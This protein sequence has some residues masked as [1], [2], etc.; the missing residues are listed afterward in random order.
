MKNKFLLLFIL[1]FPLLGFSQNRKVEAKIGLNKGTS[2]LDGGNPLG[3][4]AYF[5]TPLKNRWSLG[6]GLSYLKSS[7]VEW[8]TKEG[9]GGFLEVPLSFKEQFFVIDAGIRY[10]LSPVDW[11]NQFRVGAGLGIAGMYLD[12]IQNMSISGYEVRSIDRQKDLAVYPLYHV[13]FEHNIRMMDHFLFFYRFNLS[14]RLKNKTLF[15]SRIEF[16]NG[17]S[18]RNIYSG[19]HIN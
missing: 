3:A 9:S 12:F 7:T 8:V 1:C 17:S 5:D 18:E 13:F 15:T 14:G 4:V 19:D 16:E 10:N 2:P 6:T 11:R